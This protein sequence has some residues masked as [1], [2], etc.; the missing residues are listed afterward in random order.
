[1]L[2][3]YFAGRMHIKKSTFFTKISTISQK[4][5]IVLWNPETL[6]ADYVPEYN[7]EN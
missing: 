7:Y 5:M 6:Q 1:M 4:S 3:T 2:E